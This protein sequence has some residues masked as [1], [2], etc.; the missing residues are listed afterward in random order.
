MSKRKPIITHLDFVRSCYGGRRYDTR[1]MDTLGAHYTAREV[2]LAPHGGIFRNTWSIITKALY[3]VFFYRGILVLTARTAV[4]AGFAAKKNVLIVH[5]I[6]N[7]NITGLPKLLGK[8]NFWY[9]RRFKNR[10]AVVITV[11]QYWKQQ[12]TEWKFPRVELLYNSLDPVTFDIL[13]SEVETFICKYQLLN[14]PV[15]YLG[16]Q[17]RAKGADIAYRHLSHLDAHFVTTGG[18]DMDLPVLHLDLPYREYLCLLKSA[19]MVVLMSRFTEGWNRIAHE[20]V[21]CGTPVI[22]SGTGG[23][24]EVLEKAGMP[25]CHTPE[26]LPKHYEHI[27]SHSIKPD[28]TFFLELNGEYFDK[29]AVRIMGE[30]FLGQVRE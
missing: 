10:F 6:D 28:R 16:N 8:V 14:K 9:M 12:F 17:L 23:M 30:V 25:V 3:Y 18:R 7:D 20:A 24:K 26:D 27:I 29:N 21:M 22:G 19:Q 2:C 1:L 11:S 13:P 15:I 5:H 4:F